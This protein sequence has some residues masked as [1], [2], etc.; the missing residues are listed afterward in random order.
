MATK[1][2]E[3][4]ILGAGALGSILGA[5]LARAGHSVVMLARGQRALQ[6]AR[7]GLRISGIISFEQQVEI[8][9]EPE[10][11]AGAGVFVLA[12]KTHGTE[13]ALAPYRNAPVEL[14]FSVQNGLMKNEQL[15]A[16]F[17]RQHV[18][19]ALANTSGE[20]LRDG[21][22]LF[23]RNE[24]LTVGELAGG[25]SARATRLAQVLDA[26]GVRA[27]AVPDIESL[28]WSKFVGWAGLMILSVVT[29]APTVDFLD[30]A[31]SA[32]VVTR[33]VREL[34]VL[35]TACAV[36]LSDRTTLPV[37]A[38]CAGTEV[39][40]VAIVRAFAASLRKTAP[41]HR[42]SSLQDL[43][44]GHRLEIEETLG[45]AL[46][47]SL[48]ARVQLPLLA[49]LYPLVRAIDGRQAHRSP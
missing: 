33:I 47:R 15:A 8:V 13:Q 2:A 6:I 31:D 28:E 45:Y 41:Q 18:L 36:A 27:A 11:F 22:V 17:G 46:R 16:V 43:E 42:M 7:E 32:L 3:F 14:A 12:T 38:M 4:A 20:L 30:D 34:G 23:T 26:S 25:I 24:G 10:R 35:A 40:G 37:A 9:S 5:H 19:G 49:T 21:T 29:R 48:E 44:A 1:T 39:E